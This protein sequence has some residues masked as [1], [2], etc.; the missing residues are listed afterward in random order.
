[1]ILKRFFLYGGVSTVLLFSSLAHADAIQDLLDALQ[2]P[3]SIVPS[4]FQLATTSE[5]VMPT[6]NTSAT[7]S[8][9]EADQVASLQQLIVALTQQLSELLTKKSTVSTSTS[10]VMPNNIT[11]GQACSIFRSL[12]RG[13]RGEDV[14]T[15]QSFLTDAGVLVPAFIT[16][17]FGARTE[18]ALQVW[19]SANGVVD[20]G[21]PSTTGYGFVG[22]KT[23]DAISKSCA[24]ATSSLA[25]SS[26]INATNTTNVTTTIV[27]NSLQKGEPKDIHIY[28]EIQGKSF[29]RADRIPVK[30]VVFDPVPYNGAYLEFVQDTPTGNNSFG[31]KVY[32]PLGF[33]GQVTHELNASHVTFKSGDSSKD[34]IDTSLRAIIEAD[35]TGADKAVTTKTFGQSDLKGVHITEDDSTGEA[36][37]SVNG[38]SMDEAVSSWGKYIRSAFMTD[39]VYTSYFMAT[40]TS[41][42]N[43]IENCD[44][45]SEILVKGA[46]FSC[47]WGDVDV[48]GNIRGK[49][50]KIDALSQ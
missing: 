27:S 26:M 36:S 29:S 48:S 40:T 19:Q 9:S 38:V 4:V 28:F 37:F 13:M 7:S 6:T 47:K 16:G 34:G 44:V 45:F 5:V 31:S 39:P 1:M 49:I 41:R 32:L 17:V 43:A 11:S 42:A 8:A 30:V 46:T 12:G 22:A 33:T 21:S 23:R 35:F 15:L 2:S 18:T 14:T 24:S 10:A 3:P 20:H 50:R 25:T